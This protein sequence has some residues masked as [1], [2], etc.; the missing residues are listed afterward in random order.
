LIHYLIVIRPIENISLLLGRLTPFRW[1]DANL[2]Y[3]LQQWLIDWLIIYC[4][5]SR[6]RT[7]HLFED[8]TIIGEGLQNL[9]LCSVLRAFEQGGIF[10]VTRDL[11]FPGLILKTAPFSRL[12]RHTRGCGGYILTRILI[13]TFSSEVS[14]TCRRL[15]RCMASE[16]PDC[17]F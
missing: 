9:G 3:D 4:F 12:L 10:I 5:T 13:G 2:D 17:H 14:F 8:V 1:R 16:R 6:S 15:S 7:F 11:G